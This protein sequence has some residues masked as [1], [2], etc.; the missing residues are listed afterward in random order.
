MPIRTISPADA[1]ALTAQG[2]R[3]VDIRSPD[4][5]R[6]AKAKG[7]ENQPLEALD[8]FEDARPV[9]FM[10]KSGMRTR[11]NAPRLEGCCSGEAY[12]VDGGL[13]AWQGAGL[14]VHEDPSQPLEIMRQVQITAGILILVGVLLGSLTTPLW[15]GLS[16]FVGAG[17]LFAGATGWCGMANLLMLMPWNRE[18]AT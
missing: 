8:Q 15:Y 17:L 14:P 1:I 2:A 3:L 12:I 16:A 10:C 9:V 6:R 13:D 18:A 7:A 11:T 4:E 5:F